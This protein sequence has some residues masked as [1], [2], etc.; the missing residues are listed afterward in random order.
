[1]V[2]NSSDRLD[3]EIVLDRTIPTDFAEGHPERCCTDAGGFRQDFEQIG[4]S[5]REAS[6]RGEGALLSEQ[7]LYGA[8]TAGTRHF[9]ATADNQNLRWPVSVPTFSGVV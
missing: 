7:L 6:E 5:E 3:G 1:M 8:I 9:Y 4:L 2:M